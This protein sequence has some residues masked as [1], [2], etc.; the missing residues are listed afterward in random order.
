[1]KI[2]EKL[3]FNHVKYDEVDNKH[4]TWKKEKRIK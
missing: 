4:K 1:M 2:K 3:F